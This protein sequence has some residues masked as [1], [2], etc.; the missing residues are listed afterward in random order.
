MLSNLTF[1]VM[2]NAFGQLPSRWLFK[3][4]W[5]A[6]RLASCLPG[7]RPFLWSHTESDRLACWRGKSQVAHKTVLDIS[8]EGI[9]ATE[10]NA[11]KLIVQSKDGPLYPIISFNRPFILLAVTKATKTLVFIRKVENPTQF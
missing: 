3:C 8:E 9:Q 10:A 7:R 5:G 4:P 11:T 6:R 1:Q 2:Q